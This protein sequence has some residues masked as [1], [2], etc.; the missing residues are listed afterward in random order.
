M[1]RKASEI[2]VLVGIRVQLRRLDLGMTQG[3]LAQLLNVSCQ[4]I[5]KYE[6][7]TNRISAGCLWELSQVLSVPITFFFEDW[8][9]AQRSLY[10]RANSENDRSRKAAS[11]RAMPAS[12]QAR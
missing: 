6:T 5:Q 7:G 11:G 8:V 12:R 9:G 1:P 4:Q 3:A 10:G 2:D